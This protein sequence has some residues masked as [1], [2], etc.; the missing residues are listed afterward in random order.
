[1]PKPYPLQLQPELKE[2]V[3]G[4]QSLEAML[5]LER[6]E[7]KVGEAWLVYEDLRVA[8]GALAGQTLADLTR[9]FP[10]AMLGAQC[11]AILY[12]YARAAISD[13]VGNGGFPPFQLQPINFDALY[14]EGLRQRAEQQGQADALQPGSET[15]GN[16]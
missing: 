4:G 8:N 5:G 1:M 9:S 16:A 15:A 12:P 13:L 6:S 14:A 2:K 11:P 3:W 7:R 10:D